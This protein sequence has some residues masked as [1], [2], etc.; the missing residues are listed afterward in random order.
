MNPSRT[1]THP[2]HQFLPALVSPYGDPDLVDMLRSLLINS[3]SQSSH[4]CVSSILGFCVLSLA[5]R[6]VSQGV[7][8]LRPR[9]SFHSA[10]G[11][12]SQNT[13]AASRCPQPKNRVSA[14]LHMMTLSFDVICAVDA[15]ESASRR[16]D[17]F[18]VNMLVQWYIGMEERT[19]TLRKLGE[20]LYMILLNSKQANT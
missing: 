8:T 2:S 16:L 9:V 4:S 6:H 18:I 12:C 15:V 5:L 10:F 14:H 11:H 19:K 3:S 7:L 17:L 20:I 13:G 1:T